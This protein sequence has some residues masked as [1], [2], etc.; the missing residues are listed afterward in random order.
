MSWTKLDDRFHSH[1]KT[2]ACS[3]EAIGAF[4]VSLSWAGS[5]EKDGY[6]PP[7]AARYL[8]R[9]KDALIDELVH[10]GLWDIRGDGYVIH[11]YLLYNPSQEKLEK[12]RKDAQLRMRSLRSRSRK[13]RANKTFVARQPVP[14]GRDGTGNGS[15]GGVPGEPSTAFERFWSLYPRK[16]AKPAAVKAWA[17]LAP[18]AAL[19][20]RI[21]AAVTVQRGW[22]QWQRD[23]GQFIPHPATW[24]H[25]RR[26][27]DEAPT[28]PPVAQPHSS[29]RIRTAAEIRAEQDAEVERKRRE[30]EQGPA[31]GVLRSVLGGG[32]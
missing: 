7:H 9:G 31:A 24:L 19:V 16:V 3:L 12:K 22:P 21:V 5:Q 23:G 11:D 29:R 10:V 13:V 4:A 32:T 15:T 20:D 8:A 30:F 26:W 18:D 27:E 28:V 1:S 6:I 25:A 14:R 2:L 17:A